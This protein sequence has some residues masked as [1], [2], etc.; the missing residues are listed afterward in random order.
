MNL[1]EQAV[2]LSLRKRSDH[3]PRIEA[4]AQADASDR[5]LAYD[6]PVISCKPDDRGDLEPGMRGAVW[7]SKCYC[8]T[9]VLVHRDKRLPSDRNLLKLVPRSGTCPRWWRKCW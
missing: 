5:R 8:D 1:H 2:G 9:A 7:A 3:K 4:A 6:L